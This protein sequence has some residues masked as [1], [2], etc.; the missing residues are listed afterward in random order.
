[1][2]LPR[3]TV[4]NTISF[5]VVKKLFVGHTGRLGPDYFSDLISDGEP[6]Q[7]R[8]AESDS[9]TKNNLHKNYNSWNNTVWEIR[10]EE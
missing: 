10:L 8:F 2:P 7:G 1:V 5:Q 4:G 3:K 6:Y 9:A